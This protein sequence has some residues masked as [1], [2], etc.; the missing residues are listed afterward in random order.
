MLLVR[1][2]Y[3]VAQLA[4]ALLCKTIVLL[5]ILPEALCPWVRLSL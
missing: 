1:I 3:V 4:E 2:G 5:T